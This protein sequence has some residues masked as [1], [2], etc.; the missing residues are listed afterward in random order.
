MKASTM[1]FPGTLILYVLKAAPSLWPVLA[2]KE[3]KEYRYIYVC[4]YI[5][6]I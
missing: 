4:I 6:F 2:G 3:T 1:M 5:Y